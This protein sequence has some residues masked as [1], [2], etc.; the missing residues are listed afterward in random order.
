MLSGQPDTSVDTALPP[1]PRFVGVSAS[2][3]VDSARIT[4]EPVPGAKDYRVYELPADEDIMQQDGVVSVSNAIYRCAGNRQ[5]PR[6]SVDAEKKMQ[7]E[8]VKTVVTGEPVHGFMRSEE[9][10]KLGYVYLTPGE[11][12]VP[13]YVL[14]NPEA[15]AD[16]LCFH[17]RWNATRVKKYVTSESERA[18]L[19]A[20]SWR[21]D[22]IAF[23]VPAS[24]AAGT[25]PVY[26][27]ETNDY[28][29]AFIDGPEAEDRGDGKAIFDVLAE[30]PSP[31][32]D[33]IAPLM[34]VHYAKSCAMDHDELVAGLP[35]FERVRYQGDKLPM[36][37]LRWSGITEE[38]TLVI[39]A[40]DGLC[41][42]QGVLAPI[43]SPA[44]N[45]DNIDYPAF[46]TLDE[47]R[48][49]ETGEVFVNG[50]GDGKDKP[51][52]IARS[53]LKVS[54]GPKPELDWFAGF[55]P[56]ESFPDFNAGSWNE[57]CEDPRAPNCGA[58]YRQ[59]SDW[60]EV[61]FAGATKDRFGIAAMLGEL[62]V[63]Y[64]DVGA[65]VGGKVRVS[66]NVRASMS[67]TAF[68]HV[69]M[70]VDAFS[71]ARRYPQIF[72]SDGLSPVQSNLTTSNT[73]IIQT[74]RDTGGNWPNVFHVQVCDHRNWEVN[75]QCPYADLYRISEAGEV[76]ALMPNQEVA[77]LSGVDVASRFDAFVSTKRA[78]LFLNNQPHACVDLPAKGVPKGDVTVAFGD[79]LYHSG[80]DNVFDFH[81]RR[82]QAF[83]KRHFDNL[84]FKSGAPAP[85][86]DESRYPCVAASG[87]AE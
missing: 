31:L 28:V 58:Q 54:P 57:P 76:V 61:H 53:F 14:G 55:G 75:D 1:V 40:L 10:A 69:T 46:S 26:V 72:I 56:D 11:G 17:Q 60:G 7:S 16:N 2:I 13:V 41:P 62:W 4:V 45:Y 21:D 79:V 19:L 82:Q 38:T 64:S 23:Y 50:Q 83:T 65:S 8:A 49:P 25:R 66:P 12:R 68:L 71:T 78:Y 34:R 67:D 87:F 70:E 24:G 73:V 74:F 44:G 32:P 29:L 6:L 30:E 81:A 85:K 18:D 77:E 20:K 9:D 3:V 80:V 59:K 33:D 84:G 86:W 42:F 43:S 36:F 51:R 52:A 63:I 47:L 27:S 15:G 37:D 35:R 5:S 48:D 22:G 39:E